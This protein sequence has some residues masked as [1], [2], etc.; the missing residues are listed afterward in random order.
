LR[1]ELDD[2][3]IQ[4]INKLDIKKEIEYYRKIKQLEMER[5]KRLL[6]LIDNL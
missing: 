3:L 6:E 5:L 1:E 2:E 4:S